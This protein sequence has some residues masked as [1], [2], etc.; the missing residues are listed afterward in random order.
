MS[1][2]RAWAGAVRVSSTVLPAAVEVATVRRS[3]RTGR[4]PARSCR[5]APGWPPRDSRTEETVTVRPMSS[6]KPVP[7][8]RWPKSG[9]TYQSLNQGVAAWPEIANEA[10]CG[11]SPSA[12]PAGP[13]ADTR[14]G[15]RASTTAAG[16]G[17]ALAGGVGGALGLAHTG[18]ELAAG[19]ADHGQHQDG[20]QRGPPDP[21]ALALADR[22]LRLEGLG[23]GDLLGGAPP[24]V[25]LLDQRRGVGAHRL[26]QGPD[27]APGV[28]VTAAGR[29]VVL[30]DALDDVLPDP[31]ALA[32]LGHAEPGMAARRGQCRADAHACLP[33][34]AGPSRL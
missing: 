19:E 15:V 22:H 5:T 2:Y 20:Q 9:V 11:S 25:E 10:R 28:E 21:A 14:A 32:D 24:L 33:A 7:A 30:L 8:C 18:G 13:N 3:A 34:G 4:R 26:G 6:S 1:R 17:R 23:R 16:L 27:V 12:V 31:G 29:V